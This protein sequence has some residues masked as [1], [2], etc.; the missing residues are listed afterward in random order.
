LDPRFPLQY[1][2]DNVRSTE[3]D[4]QPAADSP[5]RDEPKAAAHP[6]I[7]SINGAATGF[8]ARCN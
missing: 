3:V 4:F 6:S 5:S 8:K 7:V 1:K 2:K